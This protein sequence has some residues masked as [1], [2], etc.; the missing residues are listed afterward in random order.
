MS[1]TK[2]R[3]SYT[4][5]TDFINGYMTTLM[6][7][8]AFNMAKDGYSVVYVTMEKEAG[9]KHLEKYNK[10]DDKNECAQR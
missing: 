9:L 7:N 5:I 8:M 6:F 3:P 1:D 10:K 2:D 4:I